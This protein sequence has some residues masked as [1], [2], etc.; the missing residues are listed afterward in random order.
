MT[1]TLRGYQQAS[2]DSLFDYYNDGNKGNPLIVTPVGAGKSLIIAEIIKRIGKGVKI[3]MLSHVK[4]LLLQDAEEMRA[5]Y[6][7]AYYGFYCAGLNRSDTHQDIIFASVQSVYKKAG[8]FTKP[9][10]VIIIDE[11]HLISHKKDTQY[12]K[13]IKDCQALNPNLTV[14][15]LTGTPFRAD[16]GRLD[17]GDNRLFDKVVYDIE[18]KYMIDYGY[19]CRPITAPTNTQYNL[20]G[21]GVKGGD[22]ILEQLE[23]AIDKYD[24]NASCIDEI[25]NLGKDRKK[26]LIFTAGVAHCQHVLEQLLE[27]GIVAEMLTGET[28][29]KERAAIIRRFSS[30]E[31]QCLVNV[32]VLTTGFNVPGIDLIAFMRPTRSPVLYIQCIGRGLRTVYA[33][34]YDLE[35]VNGRLEAI[36]NSQKKNCLILDFG[37]VVQNLGAIDTINI[38]ATYKEKDKEE[39]K[40][41]STED[42][43]RCP[44]CS[45]VCEPRQKYC[46]K[47]GYSF[48]SDIELNEKASNEAI[49]S[50]DEEPQTIKVFGWNKE[51]TLNKNKDRAYPN[52]R[53]IY[54]TAIG[55]IY[56]WIC[57]E[58]PK[59]NYARKLA[60]VWHKR[61]SEDPVPDNVNDALECNFNIPKRILVKKEGKYY[62]VLDMFFDEEEDEEEISSFDTEEAFKEIFG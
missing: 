1:K 16:T 8:C 48:I 33:S 22:Y 18:I 30:G 59:E 52:M 44:A 43:K 42:F 19:L 53:V 26:W 62:K 55:M 46:Y 41:E 4:E 29:S 28:P 40:E 10:Q 61:V 58:H 13:F 32:A 56:Q 35:T 23:E 57:Y 15:G 34:G 6:P 49:L 27:R 45:E 47:C 3:I 17:K 60:E 37:G 36:K 11:C 20:D 38:N 5:Y 50:E 2:V 12:R 24:V 54:F 51:R 14:I 39:K 21:V 31:T 25:I 9:P 7:D